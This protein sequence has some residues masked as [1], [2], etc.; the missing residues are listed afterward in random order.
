VDLR[1]ESDVCALVVCLD[2]GAHASAPGA[3]DEHVV[4][5]FHL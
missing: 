1:E 5:R 3:Y 4:R 2:G